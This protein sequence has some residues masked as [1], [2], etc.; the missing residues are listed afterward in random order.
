MTAA[1]SDRG[2]RPTPLTLSLTCNRVSFRFPP[3]R[4]S[5]LLAHGI[6][7]ELHRV[8]GVSSAEASPRTARV[9]IVFDVRVISADELA[10]AVGRALPLTRAEATA[11]LTPTPEPSDGSGERA[12]LAV[13]GA[14]LAGLLLKRL[15]LGAGAWSGNPVLLGI[16][17]I[18]TI[19][20][21][22]PFLRGG[23]RALRG[24][25]GIDTDAL[26][27]TATITSLLMRESVTALLV[28]WLLNLGE[29][30]QAITLRRVHR[31]IHDLLSVGGAD[32]WLVAGGTEQKVPLDSIA[33]GDLLSVYTGETI[34]VDGEI[35]SG[36]ASVNQAPITGESLAVYKNPGDNVFAGTIV[37]TGSVQV[38]ANRV[39][40]DTAA[41]RLIQRIEQARELR[42]PVET[43]AESFSRRFVPFSFALSVAVL[44]LTRDVRRAM[45]MLVIACPCAA[46]L[47]T[48][49]A[50][51]AAI[52]NG[53]RRG[54]LIKGGVHLEA[55]ATLDTVIFDKTGTLTAGH[56]R[57]ADVLSFDA[58][59]PPEEVLRIAASGEV[60]SRHPLAVAVL[61]RVRELEVTVPEHE[62]CE[63]IV[64][65]GM[66]ADLGGNRILV[67]N[68]QL[69]RQFSVA[70]PESL[71]AELARYRARGD[72]TLCVAVNGQTIGLIGIK[73]VLRPHAREALAAL[74]RSG[75][76]RTM[77]LSGDSVDAV[78]IVARE[79]GITESRG[80]LLPEEK[81][82]IVRSLQAAGHRVA[83]VG[84]GINDAPSLAL[85]DLGIAMGTAG[86]DVAVEAA[87]V[88]LAGDDLRD[89][90]AVLD[91]SRHTLSLVKQNYAL[92]LGINTAGLL[93]GA[94]GRL[95]P[96]MAA[97]L[98]NASTIAVVLNS[99][100][101]IRYGL[102]QSASN[103]G[104]S[105]PDIISP[106]DAT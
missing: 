36:S 61:Q 100:R 37:E 62:E 80:Q 32:A 82:A 89:V 72:A 48:P 96:V 14:V 83:M 60:H 76:R 44:L 53:A 21:G 106:P 26:I 12:R 34:P 46:G 75:V 78:E 59:Y 39:G 99:S 103:R 9:L 66:R 10:A 50:V 18:G 33:P 84:D 11:L 105:R 43:V 90:A 54:I 6:E 97:V 35:V 30:L 16:S 58:A 38:L 31:A 101:L 49:T 51:S 77:L 5:R 91:L 41:G 93:V 74:Q 67:G 1:V 69:L 70:L 57:V 81:L 17:A 71:P 94:A 85:A 42:A 98:H 95:S 4:D 29:L 47:S 64:G 2:R 63:V 20:S 56:A 24:R 25:S 55:A 79:L 8:T 73:D 86:S 40:L 65:R 92:S 23:F 52:G 22:Y 88:A 15:I 7:A 68:E 13:G 27:S 102:Q 19:V 104:A 28:I 87:D 3:V 45:T